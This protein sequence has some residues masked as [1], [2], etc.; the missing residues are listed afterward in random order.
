MRFYSLFAREKLSPFLE[1]GHFT[2]AIVSIS[3][4]AF[5]GAKLPQRI[6]VT[7]EAKS[8]VTLM[9]AVRRQRGRLPGRFR[10]GL[11][12]FFHCFPGRLHRAA[13]TNGSRGSGNASILKSFQTLS[14]TLRI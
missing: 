9:A 1:A 4:Q 3:F 10:K 11:M 12:H 13:H 2:I 8:T 7:D 6:P 14:A 5:F